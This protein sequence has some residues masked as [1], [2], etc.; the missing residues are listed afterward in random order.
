MQLKQVQAGTS[1][2]PLSCYKSSALKFAKAR[3]EDFVIQK[4]LHRLLTTAFWINMLQRIA[5]RIEIIESSAASDVYK[6]QHAFLGIF[7]RSRAFGFK[8]ARKLHNFSTQIGQRHRLIDE[9]HRRCF[10]A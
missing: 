9:F 6:R 4:L 8:L 3:L 5:L 2:L 1:G 7:H 10:F